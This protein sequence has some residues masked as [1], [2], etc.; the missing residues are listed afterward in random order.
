MKHKDAHLPVTPDCIMDYA[1]SVIQKVS[2][3]QGLEKF[4]VHDDLS[5]RARTSMSQKLPTDLVIKISS[6]HKYISKSKEENEFEE[7]FIINMDETPLYFDIDPSK[8]IEEKGSKS[9]RVHTT[10]SEKHHLMVMLAVSAAGDIL[11][12]M[13]I[14]KGKCPL[15]DISPHGCVVRVQERPL[16]IEWIR[17]CY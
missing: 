12:P 3:F 5:L 9:V 15:K 6:F 2:E 1:Y 4:M 17:V 8:C 13:I 14:F 7:R 10:G 11:P 16:M